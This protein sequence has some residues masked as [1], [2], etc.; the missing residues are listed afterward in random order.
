MYYNV[1]GT[2]VISDTSFKG[3]TR[4]GRQ[5]QSSVETLGTAVAAELPHTECVL[6]EPF[7]LV[8]EENVL[9]ALTGNN[10]LMI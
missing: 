8:W 3:G 4:P 6:Q 10:D 9:W 1:Y 2:F 7:H 5:V